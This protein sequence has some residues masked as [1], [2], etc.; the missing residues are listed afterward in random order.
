MNKKVCVT[1]L[2]ALL[3]VVVL[4]GSNAG[5]EALLTAIGGIQ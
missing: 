2:E 5:A 4:A 3:L 1:R